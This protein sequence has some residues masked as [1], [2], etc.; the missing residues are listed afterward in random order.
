MEMEILT[1]SQHN[2]KKGRVKKWQIELLR[3]KNIGVGIKN[4]KLRINIQSD[5][6]RAEIIKSKGG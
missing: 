5:R 6:A 1:R 4:S 3:I 2:M